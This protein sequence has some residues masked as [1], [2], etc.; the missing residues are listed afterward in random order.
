MSTIITSTTVNRNLKDTVF[1]AIFG[2]NPRNLLSLYNALNGTSY[3]DEK[4]LTITTI[5]D[6]IYIN[7]K[8]DVSCLIGEDLA[9]YEH[10]STY[11]P[12][13][14]IRGMLYFG[15][16]YSAI[17]EKSSRSIY[18]SKRFELPAPQYYVFYNGVAD[19][20]DREVL[21]LSDCFNHPPKDGSF[22]WT[23]TMLNINLHHNEE[24]MKSC[25]LLYEYSYFMI[26]IRIQKKVYP[27]SE[28]AVSVAIDICI[29]NN[30]LSDFLKQHRAEVIE[31]CLTSF[32]Q[33]KYKNTVYE[34]GLIEGEK[35][36]LVESGD[37]AIDVEN[38]RAGVELRN[39][40]AE[41]IR[42]I[43]AQV[44]LFQFLLARR[45]DTLADDKTGVRDDGKTRSSGGDKS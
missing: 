16:L 12:N 25:R 2:N 1:R 33:E 42:L 3:T 17:I 4:D 22:E 45:V 5:G 23:A 7:M 21:K 13:M 29:D 34:E 36:G 28:T 27:D 26:E 20:P 8:N 44:G 9:L 11:N 14:P 24:L 37:A 31:M 32:D 41:D 19:R 15:K 18:S 30:I 39:G 10:Q 40:L 6:V 38:R 43:A 35:R